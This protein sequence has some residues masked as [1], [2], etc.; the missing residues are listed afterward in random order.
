MVDAS[1][2]AIDIAAVY[3]VVVEICIGY[4]LL[5]QWEAYGSTLYIDL[6]VVEQVTVL[7]ATE[8]T[9][10]DCSAVESNNGVVDERVA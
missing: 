9:A 1:T 6:R 4:I 2:A 5:V 3:H 8:D 10:I 7:S